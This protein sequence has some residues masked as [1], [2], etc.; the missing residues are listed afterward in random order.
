[1]R[2]PIPSSATGGSTMSRFFAAIVAALLAFAIPAAQSQT[3]AALY[4]EALYLEDIKG[5]LPAAIAAYKSIVERHGGV[6]PIAAKALLQLAAC[7]EKLGRSE[8]KQAYERII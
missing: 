6:R 8:A 2:A 7:Y 4:Q 5:D 3:A 1:M